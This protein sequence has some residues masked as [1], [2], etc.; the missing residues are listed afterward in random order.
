MKMLAQGQRRARIRLARQRP[1]PTR[2][3]RLEVEPDPSLAG[4]QGE[5]RS[6]P[7]DGQEGASWWRRI[8]WTKAATAVG[9]VLGIGTLAFTGIATYYQARVANDA[10]EKS[11]DDAEKDAK[12]QASRITLWQVSESPTTGMIHIQNR[13]PDPVVNP[14]LYIAGSDNRKPLPT[15]GAQLQIPVLPPC[16]HLT[17]PLESVAKRLG[18]AKGTPKVGPIY[19]NVAAIKFSDVEGRN[20]YRNFKGPHDDRVSL[21]ASDFP[22][23]KMW[24]ALL[25]SAIEIKSERAPACEEK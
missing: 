18:N 6:A 1:H 5:S 25:G 7:S 20:W 14:W 11:R 3:R 9:V 23:V 8:D 17:F 15:F 22:E 24:H 13:S 10:L 16:S 2:V 19:W 21:P 12:S 4:G